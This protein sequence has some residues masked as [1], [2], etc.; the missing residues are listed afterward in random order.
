MTHDTVD[1]DKRTAA[2][3]AVAEVTA[4]MLVGLGTGTTAAFAIRAL[5]ARVAQGL[6]IRAVATSAAS[7]AL[8][9]TCGIDV[10][11][12]AEVASVDLTIDGADA[13]DPACRAIKGAGGAMLREKIVA[14]ASRRMVVIA[15]GSKQ[16]IGIDRAAN[17]VPVEILPFAKSAVM[18]TLG[19]GAVLRMTAGDAYRTDSGNLIADCRFD[20]ADPAPI[21]RWLESIPGVL[22]HG[23]FL[24]EVDAAYIATDGV[25]TRL[26][27]GG[28]SG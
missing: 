5:G 18:A 6:A 27:R 2:V 7:T 20:L 14:A 9:R 3:A 15:D 1:S 10:V 19:E 28:A 22:G 11:D 26:E 21:A 25:V 24:D 23:L 17:P 12:F 16:V 4:G 8:A 13:I